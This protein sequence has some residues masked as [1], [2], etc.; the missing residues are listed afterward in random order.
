M[1]FGILTKEAKIGKKYQ[2]IKNSRH[3]GARSKAFGRFI[4]E[5]FQL[6]QTSLSWISL[7][8][9]NVRVKESWATE[10]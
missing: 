10:A 2:E 8:H 9:R 1:T 6:H 7:A 5:L 3:Q 4:N